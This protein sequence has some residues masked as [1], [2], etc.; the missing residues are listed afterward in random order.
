MS[1]K[2]VEIQLTGQV[3]KGRKLNWSISGQITF[4]KTRVDVLQGTYQG[5]D[6]N[7]DQIPGGYAVGRGLSSN[8][9]TFLKPGYAP[10][11]FYLAHFTGI[12]KDGNQLFDSAGVVSRTQDQNPNPT[13]YFIDPSPKFSYGINNSFNYGAWDFNFFLRGEVGKKIFN[14][15][16]LNF[17]TIRRLPGNNVTKEAL[18]NGIKDAAFASDLWLEK[19]SYLRLDN[20]S[21]AY[22]FQHVK[23]FQNIRAWISGN[24][25]FVITKYRGLDPEIQNA[26]TGANQA[27]ID[28][29]YYGSAFYPRTRGFALGVNVT[30]K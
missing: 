22:T 16:L 26:D 6:V 2:G 23:G 27:Y 30:F 7:T 4:I 11:T 13:K 25:L 1:N 24:N 20:A 8:P 29:T 21:I 18:T 10:Y 19:A 9:I 3:M 17:E 28:V 14:N 15:T 5:F 12:D